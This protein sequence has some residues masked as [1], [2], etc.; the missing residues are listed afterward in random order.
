MLS[1]GSGITTKNEL[2]PK[3]ILR[4]NIQHYATNVNC[5]LADKYIMRREVGE[6]SYS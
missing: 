5:V 1:Q 3:S 4:F 2:A 6:Y